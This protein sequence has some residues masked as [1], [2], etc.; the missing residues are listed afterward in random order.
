MIGSDKSGCRI[1]KI[2]AKNNRSIKECLFRKP[3]ILSTVHRVRVETLNKIDR[4]LNKIDRR[5]SRIDRRVRLLEVR[6]IDN[7]VNRMK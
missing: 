5:V 3:R 7:V 1:S 4:V 2:L 6:M